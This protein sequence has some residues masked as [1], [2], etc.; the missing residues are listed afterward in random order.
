MRYD[1]VALRMYFTFFVCL[2][3]CSFYHDVTGLEIMFKPGYK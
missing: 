2:T 3:G 1:L